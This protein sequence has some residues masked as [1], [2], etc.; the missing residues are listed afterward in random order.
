MAPNLLWSSRNKAPAP[1][2]APEPEPLKTSTDATRLDGAEANDEP[3][4]L[5][6]AVAEDAG[7]AVEASDI[8]DMGLPVGVE[9]RTD[10]TE[11]VD[12]VPAP[13][14][15]P[16]SPFF[17]PPLLPAPPSPSDDDL[18]IES[19][20]PPSYEPPPTQQLQATDSL[21]LQQLR[22]IVAKMRRGD[23]VAYDFAYGD[24]GPLA[25]EIDEWFPL[26][27][28][29]DHVNQLQY[30]RV[31]FRHVWRQVLSG[32]GQGGPW[33]PETTEDVPWNDASAEA[34]NRFVSLVLEEMQSQD[35]GRRQPA[36]CAT[37]YLVLGNWAENGST[38]ANSAA[39]K[40]SRHVATRWQLD[41]MT[42]AIGT[43]A[44]Y[45]GIPIIWRAL[46]DVF[47]RFWSPDLQAKT[48]AEYE[49]MDLEL[50]NLLTIMYMAIQMVISSDTNETAEPRRQLVSLDPPLEIFMLGVTAKLRWDESETLPTTQVRAHI[51]IYE[52]ITPVF[53]NI[54]KQSAHAH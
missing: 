52:H 14:P 34:R 9:A 4:R 3:V 42:D 53:D 24:M 35:E 12:E 45:G 17:R 26:L 49:S 47:E 8:A 6:P 19:M 31:K 32:N 18:P 30:L 27:Q 50:N 33:G 39:G 23:A 54:R 43:L 29:Q 41:A 48:P 36:V 5:T 40:A 2:P 13:A 10:E 25:E 7:P 20:P 38:Q 11:P 21:S 37:T 15:D 46:V 44:A 28:T 16:P 22:S 51:D 1:A